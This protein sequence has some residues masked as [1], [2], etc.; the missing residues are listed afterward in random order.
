MIVKNAHRVALSYPN[1]Q[2]LLFF[3][4]RQSVEER[5]IRLDLKNRCE[6]LKRKVTNRSVER[7]FQLIHGI[8]CP[9]EI[10]HLLNY[11]MTKK[12]SIKP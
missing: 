11:P 3:R 7:S 9:T 1:I 6:W 5:L 4:T 2:I 10:S 12:S 8:P